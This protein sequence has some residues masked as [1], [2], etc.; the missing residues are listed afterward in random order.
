MFALGLQPLLSLRISG[1][2][3]MR[4]QYLYTIKIQRR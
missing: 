1:E 2:V 3:E 4:F